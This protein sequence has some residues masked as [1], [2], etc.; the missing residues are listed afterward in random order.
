VERAALAARLL[1]PA[2]RGIIGRRRLAD[3]CLKAALGMSDSLEESQ[4]VF[5]LAGRARALGAAAVPCL[6]A[7]A[8]A[9][10]RLKD[11]AEAHPRWVTLLTEQPVA[12]HLAN[13][14]AEAAYTAFE[15]GNPD[16]AV[17]ILGTGVTRFPDDASFALRAGW[18]ALLTANYGRS[19]QFL[20][21]GLAVGYPDD[22]KENAC[23]MLTVA[24]SLAGFPEDALT[25]YANLVEMAPAWEKTETLDALE[26]PEELKAALL[27]LM[28]LP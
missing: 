26:W 4:W 7:E 13:D 15:M 11:F 21:A 18:I 9:L 5:S 14:Y 27:E 20:L 28:P 2:T 10:T 8:L 23:L 22:R 1:D 25:H 6:R 12:E 19:Y 3:N 16:Q 17:E 24:A